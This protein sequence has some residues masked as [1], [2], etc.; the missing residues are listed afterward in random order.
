MEG[1]K[2]MASWFPWRTENLEG[3]KSTVGFYILWTWL[4][5]W[6]IFFEK[7][8]DVTVY[9]W[10]SDEHQKQWKVQGICSLKLYICCLLVKWLLGKLQSLFG[11]STSS[12]IKH[13]IPNVVMNWYIKSI[14]V[15]MNF[16]FS[17]A[18]RVTLYLCFIKKYIK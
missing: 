12:C 6:L 1:G 2:N 17:I 4:S 5:I 16:L 13:G 9:R 7:L 11:A 8:A 14:E 18:G 3:K 15:V 10:S